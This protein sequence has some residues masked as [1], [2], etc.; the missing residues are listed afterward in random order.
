[1]TVFTTNAN[2]RGRVDEPTSVPVQVDGVEVW[3]FERICSRVA[4]M[5]FYSPELAKKC[6]AAIAGFDGIY[7]A[8]TWTYPMLVGAHAA[9]KLEVPYVVSPRGSFMHWSMSQKA[10]KKQ[11]YLKCFERRAIESA[12][13]IHCTSAIEAEQTRTYGFSPPMVIVPNPVQALPRGNPESA[14]ALRRQLG[15]PDE[16]TLTIFTGRKH[17]M[18]RLDL[19]I[20]SFAFVARRLPTA[21]LA[22]VGPDY[23]VEADLRRQIDRLGIAKQVHLIGLLE[24]EKLGSVY[25]AANLLVMLSQRENFGMAAAEALAF[26][27]PVLLS[28]DVGLAV[29][30]AA[31]GAG[32]VVRPNINEIGDAWLSMLTECDLA[33]M[34]K[35]GRD[36][37]V[38][39]LS[40]DSV[41]RQMLEVFKRTPASEAGPS[42]F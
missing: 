18:K 19:T 12:R 6:N 7:I 14:C 20:E 39:R 41:G 13:A 8:G 32:K 35:A 1:M 36:F 34:G 9:Q 33:E 25:S 4:P 27:V 30:A 10:W 23:G 16:G 24:G 2:G 3:Y 22:I 11:I 38:R 17:P 21:H 37:A 28:E 42:I 31:A 40:P 26:G 29:E 5:F 15:V